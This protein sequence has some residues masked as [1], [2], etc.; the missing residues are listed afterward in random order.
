[1]RLQTK[2]LLGGLATLLVGGLVGAL[3]A[4]LYI[5]AEVAEAMQ[6][7]DRDGF[8]RHFI[9]RL[10]LDSV[11]RERLRVELAYAHEQIADIR[12]G[13]AEEY[14]AIFDSLTARIEPM[15]RPDQRRV[16][17]EER[18]RLLDRHRPPPMRDGP[19][20]IPPFELDDLQSADEGTDLQASQPNLPSKAPRTAGS[21]KEIDRDN[22]RSVAS[23]DGGSGTD[24]A[25]QIRTDEKTREHRHRP[26][27]PDP[28]RFIARVRSELGLDEAQLDRLDSA[29]ARFLA[30]DIMIRREFEGPR[31]LLDRQRRANLRQLDREIVAF[32]DNAQ[33][34][35]YRELKSEFFRRKPRE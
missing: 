2:A 3:V 25:E 1:M 34:R 13:A 32:L 18:R 4:G 16:L 19:P 33:R 20:P 35:T 30:R 14:E 15:L 10:D 28:K 21:D 5:K 6:L 22:D 26:R 29:V 27:R 24:T 8:R 17:R 11:Q 12:R 23:G 7:R 31:Y 9:E